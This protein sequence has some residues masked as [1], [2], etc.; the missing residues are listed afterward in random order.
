[1]NLVHIFLMTETR[2][3]RETQGICV[4]RN[5][6]NLGVPFLTFKFGNVTVSKGGSQHKSKCS[7]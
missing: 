2:T 1:M 6:G 7:P 5:K 4:L 3:T